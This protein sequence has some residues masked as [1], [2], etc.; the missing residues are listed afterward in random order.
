MTYL[1]WLE[2]RI[3][4]FAQAEIRALDKIGYYWLRFIRKRYE[5]PGKQALQ[6]GTRR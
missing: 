2:A 3:S 4:D 6:A 1:K 5:D